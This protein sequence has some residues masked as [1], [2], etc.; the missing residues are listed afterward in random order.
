MGLI[1][2][3]RRFFFIDDAPYVAPPLLFAFVCAAGL[4][5]RAVEREPLPDARRRLQRAFAASLGVLVL[6]AFLGRFVGYASDE[7]VAIRG[8]GSMLSARPELA[9]QIEELAAAIRGKT[10]AGDGLVVFPEGEILNF[11]SG[12]LNPLRHKLYIPG[13]LSRENEGEI[14]GELERNPPRAVVIWPRPAG[15]YREAP[16]AADPN[17]RLGR[18]LAENYR[19]APFAFQERERSRVVLGLRNRQA[20]SSDGEIR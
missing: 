1:A 8:T 10:R 2:S 17:R 14:V 16:S 11:L 12:R 5:L 15:E 9:R 20:P 3:H 18:W 19:L 13:Y 7:R 6:L 4:L